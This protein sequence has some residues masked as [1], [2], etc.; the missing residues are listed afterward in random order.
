MEEHNN[1][2]RD[3]KIWKLKIP[4][5]VS[6][7]LWLVKHGRIMTNVERCRRCPDTD[8]TCK[9]C[10]KGHEDMDHI[11]RKCHAVEEI[12]KRN[13]FNAQSLD[14]WLSTNIRGKVKYITNRNW[15]IT[16]TMFY[17]SCGNGVMKLPSGERNGV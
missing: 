5:R 15:A 7:F 3:W 11:F 14:I 6:A 10:H 4:S 16:F 8:D 12:W 2:N 9:T 1:A 17:S 13:K